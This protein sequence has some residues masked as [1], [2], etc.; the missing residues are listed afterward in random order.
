MILVTLGTQDKSFK[1][2]LDAVVKSIDEGIIT[3]RVVVQ[4]GHTKYETDKLE[5][6]D[7]LSIE[8]FNELTKQ[9]SLIITHGGVG[10][11]MSCLAKDKVI[12][13]APR[14]S[15]YLEHTNDH[16]IELLENFDEQGYII[17]AKD[18]E[19]LNEYIIKSKSFKPKQYTSNTNNMINLIKN[20][21]ENN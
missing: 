20:Y 11:I 16:Q 8:E 1:R 7:Y 15:K 10:T 19:N 21:I 5:V 3:D 18:L 12:I 14:L 6:F 17:Y 4:A 13:G 2:L 9:A